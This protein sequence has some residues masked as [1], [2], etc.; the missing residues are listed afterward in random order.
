[1]KLVMYTSIATTRTSASVA[2]GLCPI[3]KVCSKNNP[4][5][6]ITGALYYRY[7]RY[8]QII[9]GESKKIDNLMINILKDTRHKDCLVQID[10]SIK[11]RV[12]PKWQCQ[13]NM[14]IDRD[15]FLRE[16]ITQY[17]NELKSMN[18]EMSAAFNHFFKKKTIR[19]NH[20]L[21]I[22]AE[23]APCLDVF[24]RQEISIRSLPDSPMVE[25]TPLL[26]NLCNL[27]VD[28]PHSVDELVVKYGEDKRDQIL[29]FLKDLN[30]DGLLQFRS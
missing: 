12:F 5:Y 19:P 23:T 11:K 22:K 10:T 6:G 7:G 24:G 2:T 13:L 28:E 16:F 4:V 3:V 29:M 8:L 26:V 9:E 17:S 27:L 21:N 25:I 18:S 14:S 30:H 1:M 20:S 15:P